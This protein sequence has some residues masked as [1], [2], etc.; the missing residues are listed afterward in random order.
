MFTSLFMTFLEQSVLNEGPSELS[1]LLA[2]S[3]PIDKDKQIQNIGPLSKK[4]VLPNTP[5]TDHLAIWDYLARY[6]EVWAQY[7]TALNLA[8]QKES[9]GCN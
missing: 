2:Q 5:P 4:I 8:E 6:T 9:I 1:K 7:C 3:L